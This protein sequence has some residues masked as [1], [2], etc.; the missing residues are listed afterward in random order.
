M[1]AFEIRGALASDEDELLALARHLNTVNLPG[2]R[3]AVAQIL[4]LAQ[5]SFT[6]EIK[7]PKRREYVF[8][9]LDVEKA[10]II[11][12]SMIIAQLGRRDAPYIYLDV[13]DE[14]RYSA[15]LDRH[16]NHTTLSLGYSYNGPT[17]T[18]GLVLLPEYRKFPERP[19]AHLVRVPFIR[20][21]REVFRDELLAEGLLR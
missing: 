8:V 4:D 1:P 12:T 7:D 6:G 13:I 11:G 20:L 17:E 5:R 16:F 18:G 14:E 19:A 21:H 2:K 9:L 3:D 10:R 15:T